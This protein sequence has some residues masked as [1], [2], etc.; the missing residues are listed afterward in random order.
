[1]CLRH[2]WFQKTV[3]YPTVTQRR[4]FPVPEIPVFSQWACLVSLET[5]KGINL[6][7]PSSCPWLLS[8]AHPAQVIPT[9][10]TA[11]LCYLCPCCHWSSSVC[12]SCWPSLTE[13][14][15]GRRGCAVI[16]LSLCSCECRKETSPETHHDM[17]M[18]A[19]A[20]DLCQRWGDAWFHPHMAP[21]L[22]CSIS[23]IVQTE[24][25]EGKNWP[26][27]P[28]LSTTESTAA[29][30]LGSSLL[31]SKPWADEPP[32]TFYKLCVGRDTNIYT[33]LTEPTSPNTLSN[34]FLRWRLGTKH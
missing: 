27:T 32:F 26:T 25:R 34:L 9:E 31:G 15:P 14:P 17:T 4:L 5:P 13:E 20:L 24:C 23:A 29:L 18:R 7:A 11:P 28:N 1:M 30:W 10:S 6:V 22:A 8:P 21:G 3:G 19:A 2:L 12:W 16:R 33:G